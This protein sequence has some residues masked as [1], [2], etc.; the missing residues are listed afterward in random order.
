M[1]FV[2][3]KF[4]LIIY[5]CLYMNFCVDLNFN[6][7]EIN[8]NYTYTEIEIKKNKKILNGNLNFT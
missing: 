3:F 6:I 1:K 8:R 4:I 7:I 2:N 5:F